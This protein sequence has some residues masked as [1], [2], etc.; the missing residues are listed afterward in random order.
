[1]FLADATANREDAE[2]AQSIRMRSYFALLSS[3]MRLMP[4]DIRCV[5]CDMDFRTT[6][7]IAKLAIASAGL[8]VPFRHLKFP[9]TRMV[10]AQA[11]D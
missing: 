1:M 11:G 2:S 9:T 7:G 4:P 8:A 5:R 10:R 6:T 3:S